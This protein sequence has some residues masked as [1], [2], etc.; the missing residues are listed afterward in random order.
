MRNSECCVLNHIE[1]PSSV[2]KGTQSEIIRHTE[3]ILVLASSGIRFPVQ[4]YCII[5]D[6]TQTMETPPD[7]ASRL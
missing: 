4:P 3:M 6:G 7:Y 1:E 2:S 5:G